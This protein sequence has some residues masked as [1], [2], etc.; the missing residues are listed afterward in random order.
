MT[1]T[2]TRHDTTRAF[3]FGLTSS[4]SQHVNKSVRIMAPGETE[5]KPP[6]AYPQ[7]RPPIATGFNSAFTGAVVDN[8]AAVEDQVFWAGN[9]QRYFYNDQF[10]GGVGYPI[11][12]FI[13]GLLPCNLNSTALGI[14]TGRW[15]R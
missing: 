11:W 9:G 5:A 8:F 7:Q 14:L 4:A 3:D 12:V 6:S 2:R 13:G 1:R 10:W 15:C